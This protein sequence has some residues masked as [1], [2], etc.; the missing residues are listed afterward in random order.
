MKSKA[1]ARLSAVY[2]GTYMLNKPECKVII[3]GAS[4]SD[5]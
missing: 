3:T 1:F 2:G 4:V 5:S